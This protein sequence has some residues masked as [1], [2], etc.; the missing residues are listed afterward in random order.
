MKDGCV[1][2]C[3]TMNNDDAAKVKERAKMIDRF[4]YFQYQFQDSILEKRKYSV[5]LSYNYFILF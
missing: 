2:A 1:V 5:G 3:N 4:F